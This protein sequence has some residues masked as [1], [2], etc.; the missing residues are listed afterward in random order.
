MTT[1]EFISTLEQ[2]PSESLIFQLEGKDHIQPGYHVTEVMAVS[3]KTM[4][5]GGKANAWE[6]TVIQLMDP[7][8]NDEP[9]FMTV[10]KFLGIYRK[11][12]SGVPVLGG[13]ELKFEYGPSGKPALRYFVG[14]IWSENSALRVSLATTR[15]ECKAG[16]GCC[17]PS[18]AFQGF[19]DLTSLV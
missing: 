11:T 1:K 8:K 2:R 3:Y 12:L 6:E 13:A 19:S 4:D 16:D 15:V 18:P 14:E 5:C 10:E 7:G 9:V 17:A